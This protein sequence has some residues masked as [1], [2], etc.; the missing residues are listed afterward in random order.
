MKA[1]H[2]IMIVVF[3]INLMIGAYEHGKPKEGK[4]NILNNII[5]ITIQVALLWWGGFWG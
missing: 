5:G 2:I 1:P 4:S 3:V